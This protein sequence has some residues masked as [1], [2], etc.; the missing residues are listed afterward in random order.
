[1][2]RPHRGTRSTAAVTSV[3]ASLGMDELVAGE[4]ELTEYERAR[5]AQLARNRARLAALD[6]AGAVARLAPVVQPKTTAAK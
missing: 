3:P 5:A 1:M 6:L 2:S 4:E